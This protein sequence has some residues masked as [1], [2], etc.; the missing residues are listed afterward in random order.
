MTLTV[1]GAPTTEGSVAVNCG[2]D[3]Y[4]LS[5][6]DDKYVVTVDLPNET[7]DY[8]FTASYKTAENGNYESA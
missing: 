6:A 4:T 1:S 5:L 7:K 8:N 2:E 3:T